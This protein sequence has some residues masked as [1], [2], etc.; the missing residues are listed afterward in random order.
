[1]VVIERI[2]I[3]IAVIAGFCIVVGSIALAIPSYQRPVRRQNMPIAINFPATT[4][5][6]MCLHYDGTTAAPEWVDCPK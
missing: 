2:R 1:M 4:G 5:T 6:A 3:A